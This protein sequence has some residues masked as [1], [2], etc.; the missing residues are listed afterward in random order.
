MTYREFWGAMLGVTVL[1]AAS[2]AIAFGA[3]HA[4]GWQACGR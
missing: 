3:V 2:A 4:L 1:Y